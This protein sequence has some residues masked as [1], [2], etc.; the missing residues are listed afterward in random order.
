MKILHRE[1]Y[2]PLRARAYPPITDQLDAAMKMAQALHDQGM[3]LPPEVM[4]WVDQ[5]QQVKAR[6]PKN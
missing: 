2:G 6:Y 1:A 3:S 5:C 4:E